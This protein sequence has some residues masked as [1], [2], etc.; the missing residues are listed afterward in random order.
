MKLEI[1]KMSVWFSALC[2]H[3]YNV[4]YLLS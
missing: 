2:R 1:I 4:G 3:W